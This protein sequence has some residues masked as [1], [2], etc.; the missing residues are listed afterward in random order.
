MMSM[1]ISEGKAMGAEV[2]PGNDEE[3]ER[4][5]ADACCGKGAGLIWE[6]T[7]AYPD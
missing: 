2:V 6:M 5:L 3:L 4:A 7:E 1:E